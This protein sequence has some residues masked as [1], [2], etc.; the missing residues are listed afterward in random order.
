MSNNSQCIR[1]VYYVNKSPARLKQPFPTGIN[2]IVTQNTTP[3]N[4]NIIAHGSLTNSQ[5]NTE[6]TILVNLKQ[7]QKNIVSNPK[8]IITPNITSLLSML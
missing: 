6:N 2:K 8:L 3:I 5:S 1:P 4:I 7:I